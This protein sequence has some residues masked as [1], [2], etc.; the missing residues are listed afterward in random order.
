[1][2]VVVRALV[3]AALVVAC[4][5]PPEKGFAE[6]CTTDGDCGFGLTCLAVSTTVHSTC[7]AGRV[8]RFCSR[9]CNEIKDCQDLAA[10]N[11][12]PMTCTDGCSGTPMCTWVGPK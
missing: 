9:P 1:M 5:G 11:G 7:E 10:P 8:V 3:L 12:Y 2:K 4:A 6:G